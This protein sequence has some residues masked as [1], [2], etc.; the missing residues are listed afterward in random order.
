M[1]TAFDLC[2]LSKLIRSFA[3][4][5]TASNSGKSVAINSTESEQR[6]I[7][8]TRS[9]RISVVR[10]FLKRSTSSSEGKVSHKSGIQPTDSASSFGLVPQAK[11]DERIDMSALR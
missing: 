3:T 1:E 9:E 8:S 4:C 5:S 6:L 2:L 10:S 11:R 7:E